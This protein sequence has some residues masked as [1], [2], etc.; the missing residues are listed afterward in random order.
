MLIK[1][2]FRL[3]RLIF[4][5]MFFSLSGFA[6]ALTQTPHIDPNMTRADVQG[7]LQ[8][9]ANEAGI[10]VDLKDFTFDTQNESAIASATIR[11][12]ENLQQSDFKRH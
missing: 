8:Q 6:V 5:S 7:L 4:M 9:A 10:D 1:Y 3:K 2:F 11:G 12:M